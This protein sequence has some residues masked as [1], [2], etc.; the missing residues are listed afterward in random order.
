VQLT[1]DD[2]AAAAAAHNTTVSRFFIDCTRDLLELTAQRYGESHLTLHDPL[3]VGVVID[4]SFVI[5]EAMSVD[6]E[7]RGELTEGMT[8]ADRR[9]IH[10]SLKEPLTA[11][12]CTNV[13]APR[14]IDF[15]LKR[16]LT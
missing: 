7:T 10:P 4:P 5:A 11:D 1:A 2:I 14:F 8:L 9:P 16:L 12:V 6:I 3:A 15:F 13:D